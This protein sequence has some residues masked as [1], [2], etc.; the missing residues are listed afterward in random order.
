MDVSYSCS[1]H[2]KLSFTYSGPDVGR[3]TSQLESTSTN[4]LHVSLYQHTV[5]DIS[6]F[7][8]ISFFSCVLQHLMCSICSKLSMVNSLYPLRKLQALDYDKQSRET[9]T[10]A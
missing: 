10:T 7:K 6:V 2:G 3:V 8:L 1:T 5:R 9:G 4:S